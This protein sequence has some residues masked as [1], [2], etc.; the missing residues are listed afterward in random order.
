[1]TNRYLALY[2][3]SRIAS[4]ENINRSINGEVV[5]AV[6]GE[7]LMDAALHVGLASCIKTTVRKFVVEIVGVYFGPR[8]RHFATHTYMIYEYIKLETSANC[9]S[10]VFSL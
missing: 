1:M 4:L 2:F 7:A 6:Q 5:G 9:Q 3:V 10:S 8:K